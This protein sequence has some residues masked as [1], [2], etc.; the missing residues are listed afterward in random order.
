[1]PL[2]V[3]WW[4]GGGELSRWTHDWVGYAGNVVVSGAY[5]RCQL[6]QA[7]FYQRPYVTG[8]SGG[9]VQ[10]EAGHDVGYFYL[11][12]S[13]F[14]TT[15][16]FNS[17]AVDLTGVRDNQGVVVWQPQWVELDPPIKTGQLD[18][19]Y[20]PT[21]Y[22]VGNYKTGFVSDRGGPRVSLGGGNADAM[23]WFRDYPGVLCRMYHYNP[24][25]WF[26]TV[27]EVIAAILMK[28]GLDNSFIDI[29]AFDNAYDAYDLTTGD[30][31]WTG[32][33]SKWG[34]HC[35][36]KVG[37]TC[38]DLLADCMRH[39]RDLYY[40]AESG[41]FSVSSF[42][43]PQN[44]LSSL[45]YSDG[46]LHKV[47]WFSSTELLFNVSNATRGAATRTSGTSAN[48]PDGS[49]FSAS[50]E[51]RLESHRSNSFRT[52]NSSASSIAKYGEVY[53]SESENK[54]D[55]IINTGGAPRTTKT[56]HYP[57]LL[58]G[59]GIPGTNIA[60]ITNWLNS[61]GKPRKMITVKQD[62][63]GF[64][65]GIGDQVQNVAL[66]SD[67][68]TA[69]DTRCIRKK[70]NFKDLTVESLLMEVPDNTTAP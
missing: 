14:P 56:V 27:P 3:P 19:P 20:N 67:D 9:N 44:I 29:V 49:N 38:Y 70:Y 66:T 26:G 4:A 48:P 45:D 32:G 8:G 34:I 68:I 12:R 7:Q 61:D 69:V 51:P 63:Q 18:P 28:T 31:P 22:Y 64:N 35:W 46:V 17:M 40:V 2:G 15:E 39:S 42:T 16:D 55:E 1:M 62:C 33:T 5:V 37:Q 6:S 59:A 52:G 24:W 57:F 25:A 21:T 58:S 41:K 36:R 50:D 11:I 65:F 13:H 54:D 10:V 60:H 43:R 53:L 30:A 23:I 47:S